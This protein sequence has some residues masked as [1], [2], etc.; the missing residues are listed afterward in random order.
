[1]SA[2]LRLA[3]RCF[4]RPV[5]RSDGGGRRPDKKLKALLHKQSFSGQIVQPVLFL[6]Q[7]QQ[8]FMH[9]QVQL[10]HDITQSFRIS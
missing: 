4:I 10:T 1:M 6:H 5:A 8:F 9:V 3:N 7:H 2:G